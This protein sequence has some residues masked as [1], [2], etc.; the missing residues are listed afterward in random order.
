M[1]I[2]NI[3]ISRRAIASQYEDGKF[4]S[5]LPKIFSYLLSKHDDDG[6]SGCDSV[7]LAVT[8]SFD[9]DTR[10]LLGK[11]SVVVFDLSIAHACDEIIKA[12]A[13]QDLADL[14]TFNDFILEMLEKHL[15]ESDVFH[16]SL[17]LHMCR[18]SLFFD[19]KHHHRLR[20]GALPIAPLPDDSDW[21]KIKL[22]AVILAHEIRHH[23]IANDTRACR[24]NGMLRNWIDIVQ[25][26]SFSELNEEEFI[27]LIENS[28]E[29]L[30][31][32]YAAISY[33]DDFDWDLQISSQTPSIDFSIAMFSLA[34]YFDLSAHLKYFNTDNKYKSLRLRSA[35]LRRS[36]WAVA[37]GD[38]QKALNK[39]YEHLY[40]HAI[41]IVDN[42][43]RVLEFSPPPE[44]T[45][46]TRPDLAIEY[47]NS[48][49]RENS[50][51][52]LS[53]LESDIDSWMNKVAEYF[54]TTNDFEFGLIDSI[55]R[56]AMTEPWL[57][58]T[59]DRL[60]E[61]HQEDTV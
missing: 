14:C 47:F 12:F 10:T 60:F 5:Y 53:F 45:E 34:L 33:V 24:I 49:D 31:C 30:V 15:Y 44:I 54:H 18:R 40:A 56:N 55:C 8:D 39:K 29:E 3:L 46:F 19:Y 37:G 17:W 9:R 11:E 36:T 1:T 26:E 58:P 51:D 2:D 43:Q 57:A 48:Y 16:H 20:R 32:D 61:K 23:L 38:V 35:V 41:A 59:V 4:F 6:F 21:V 27:A 52:W 50:E 7:R 22:K 25:D 13:A 42:L 28:A